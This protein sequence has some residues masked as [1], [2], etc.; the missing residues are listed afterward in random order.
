MTKVDCEAAR[1]SLSKA[2]YDKLFNWLVKRLNLSILPPED[3]KQASSVRKS[4]KE[5]R[6]STFVA[7]AARL[8]IGLLDIFG[9][10]NFQVLIN[11]LYD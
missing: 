5:V 8:S 4:V 1:D 6:R 9:F 10:E 11:F 3:L 2:L 7:G